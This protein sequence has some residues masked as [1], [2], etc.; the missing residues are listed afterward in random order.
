[1]GETSGG[2]VIVL[3]KFVPGNVVVD[4]PAGNY[5][6]TPRYGYSD[7]SGKGH[8]GPKT[9]GYQVLYPTAW[10]QS[11]TAGRYM[12]EFGGFRTAPPAPAALRSTTKPLGARVHPDTSTAAKTTAISV[13]DTEPGGADAPQ[14]FYI[15]DS[16][17]HKAGWVDGSEVSEIET[18]SVSQPPA[19]WTDPEIGDPEGEPFL[20]LPPT[21]P[22]SVSLAQPT[23]GTKLHVVNPSGTA[24]ALTSEAWVEGRV[25]ATDALTGVG[26]GQAATIDSPALDSVISTGTP[27]GEQPG[28]GGGGG[29]NPPG[30]S[31]SGQGTQQPSGNASQLGQSSTRALGRLTVGR[32]RFGKHALIAALSCSGG[33]CS[34]LA[35]LSIRHAGKTV[36]IAT[37]RLTLSSGAHAKLTLKLN[38]T[39]RRLLAHTGHLTATLTVQQLGGGPPRIVLR[40]SLKI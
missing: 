28:G 39:G 9:C 21:N 38:G 19:S 4:D 36:T 1:M 16:E 13:Y 20:E 12:V 30:G 8:Y 27:G 25:T 23:A 32:V 11:F 31:S 35:L 29:G 7:G 18:A 5:F 17:G 33:S 22:R 37:G 40:R 34:S 26:T 24:Y 3:E 6:S 2:H 15:E 10:I 14:S